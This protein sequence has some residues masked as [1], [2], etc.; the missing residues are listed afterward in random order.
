M[1]RLK[2]WRPEL[3]RAMMKVRPEYFNWSDEEQERY[4]VN[5]P[6]KDRENLDRAIQGELFGR[7]TRPS[8][9]TKRKIPID[10]Q[11]LLNE[12]ILPL[13]GIGDDCF[14]L[15]EWLADRKSVV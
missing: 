2:R 13:T 1:T 7:K 14:Y 5:M 15:N 10:H 11:N 8:K 9:G 6:S 4:G 3:R 12:I